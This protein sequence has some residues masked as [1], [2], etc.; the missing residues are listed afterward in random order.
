MF[1]SEQLVLCDAVFRVRLSSII[2]PTAYSE[3]S[4]HDNIFRKSMKTNKIVIVSAILLHCASYTESFV[5]ELC[6]Y[7]LI[8]NDKV[9]YKF[10]LNLSK[11][12]RFYQTLGDDE[13]E[14]EED[15]EEE[16]QNDIRLIWCN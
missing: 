7:I 16:K 15:N 14:K 12:I 5:M 3:V 9:L 13:G 6:G 4:R 8:R 10:M 2:F 1:Y 11:C